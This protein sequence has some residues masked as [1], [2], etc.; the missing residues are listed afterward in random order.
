MAC[1]KHS[2]HCKYNT[3]QG[4]TNAQIQQTERNTC[5]PDKSIIL[6]NHPETLFVSVSMCSLIYG[7]TTG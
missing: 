7:L 3:K 5:K 1:P 4:K 2:Q 6:T